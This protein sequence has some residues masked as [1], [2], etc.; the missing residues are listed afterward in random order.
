MVACRV[1]A[2]TGSAAAAVCA[3]SRILVQTGSTE[4]GSAAFFATALSIWRSPSAVPF[5]TTAGRS[6][7][8]P[9]ASLRRPPYRRNSPS[10]PGFEL[11][12]QRLHLA[13]VL[14]DVGIEIRTSSHDH[15]DTFDLDVGDAQPRRELADLPFELD[16][17]AI[18]LVEP[19]ID[20]PDAVGPGHRLADGK[21]LAGILAETL[22][23]SLGL[24][25]LGGLHE[26]SLLF[27]RGLGPMGP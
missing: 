15:A 25:G 14:L 17:L 3:A 27:R 21:R 16:G 26:A 24:G 6:I 8:L 10:G 23:V 12:D 5:L 18:G 1:P 2:S 9:P 7:R 22:A 11:V 4:R 19:A 13:A 20:D